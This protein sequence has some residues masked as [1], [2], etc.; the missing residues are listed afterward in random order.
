[1]ASTTPKIFTVQFFDYHSP[2]PPHSFL[3]SA[4][5]LHEFRV[6]DSIQAEQHMSPLYSILIGAHDFCSGKKA[7]ERREGGLMAP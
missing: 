2:H 3:I 5:S 7:G 6:R 4:V 1:M